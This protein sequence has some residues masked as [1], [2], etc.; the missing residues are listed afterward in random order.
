MCLSQAN[1]AEDNVKPM[2]VTGESLVL[3]GLKPG[4]LWNAQTIPES[5]TVRSTYDAGQENTTIY[6]LGRDYILDSDAGTIA[7]SQESRIPD[8]SKSV[9]YGQLDFDHNDFPGF[10]NTEYFVFVDYET[11]AGSALCMETDQ[12]T[13][14]P[15]TRAKLSASGPFKIVVFGDSIS[16]GGD[17]TKLSLRFQQRYA[18]HLAEKF[19]DAE[20][21]VEN[22][23]TGGDSTYTGLKRLEDKVLTRSPDLVLVGFGMNDHNV[24][25]VSLDTF[26]QNLVKIIAQIKEETDAEVILLST[27]P[28]NPDWKFGSSCMAD[29]AATT[30][31][32]AKEASCA[33]ADVYSA[34]M[35]VLQRK[36]RHSLL[37]NN[38][39]HPN[40]F[41]H[42]I[43]FEALKSILF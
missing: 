28:P 4:T 33:F 25:G 7:R 18:V 21:M 38:I 36:D 39:N 17:A 16:A 13:L 20:I 34:W 41:G 19:P 8:F 26:E 32:V 15:R 14:L 42:W 27:F 5:V 23:A 12:A 35:T 10:G 30:R 1:A 43:Y 40:D 11:H 31:R 2:K 3:E 9:L 6:E 24:G 22:G 29:Y 37:G